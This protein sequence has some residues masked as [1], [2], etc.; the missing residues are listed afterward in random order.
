MNLRTI[1]KV[2]SI[3][4]L[5]NGIGGI[6]LSNAF[7]GAAGW[8]VTADMVTLGQIFGLTLLI[9]GIWA[10]RIPD[11]TGDSM[12]S[13]GMLF[14]LGGLLWTLMI[15][16]HVATGAASGPTAYVNLVITAIFAVLFY[17]YSRD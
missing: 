2:Q 12:K 7:F 14:A 17:M 11:V 4:L 9:I 3:I 15:I 6:F 16:F 8:E 1:F 10:W 13:M 5:I